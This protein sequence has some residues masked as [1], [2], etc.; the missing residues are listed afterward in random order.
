MRRRNAGDGTVLRSQTATQKCLGPWESFSPFAL[1]INIY[2]DQNIYPE[3][4]RGGGGRERQREREKER[5]GL[6][7]KK[8]SHV[9]L[10]A[11][12]GRSVVLIDS[13]TG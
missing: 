5:E 1:D 10:N 13:Q 12:R 2:V 4:Y 8:K 9:V 6:K 7:L 11:A 3:V